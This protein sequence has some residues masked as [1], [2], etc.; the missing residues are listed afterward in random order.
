MR[1]TILGVLLGMIVTLLAYGVWHSTSKSHA[2]SPPVESRLVEEFR[3]GPHVLG[4]VQAGEFVVIYPEKRV[5]KELNL[6]T[7]APMAA[8]RPETALLDLS[9]YEGRVIMVQGQDQ[10]RWLYSAKVIDQATPIMTV[11]V[12]ELFAGAKVRP[13]GR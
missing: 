12:R 5:G 9:A 7:I 11:V 13:L 2:Q 8:Q 3:G 1:Q 6:T 10:G 4:F